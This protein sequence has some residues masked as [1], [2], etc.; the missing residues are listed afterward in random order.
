MQPQR[1]FSAP[2]GMIQHV[3][4]IDGTESRPRGGH[5]RRD[6]ALTLVPNL[7]LVETGAVARDQ[8]CDAIRY[9]SSQ[10]V[11][12]TRRMDFEQKS[13]RPH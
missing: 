11:H 12:V 9:Y 6:N 3:L 13:M 2:K 4:G 7:D 1:I 10:R 5:R 8:S